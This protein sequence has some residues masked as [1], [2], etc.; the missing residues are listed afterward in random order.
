[1]NKT[2]TDEIFTFKNLIDNGLDI[3]IRVEDTEFKLTRIKEKERYE[4][5]VL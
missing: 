5:Q 2:H 3:I 4:I 1:M